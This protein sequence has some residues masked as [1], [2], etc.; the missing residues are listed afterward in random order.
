MQITHATSESATEERMRAWDVCIACARHAAGIAGAGEVAAMATRVGDWDAAIALIDEQGL[1]AL[2]AH[3]ER[4]ETAFHVTERVRVAA[5]QEARRTLAL[6]RQ[7]TEVTD[8]LGAAGV[9]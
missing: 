2:L 9:Q 4:D 3:A 7:L 5:S 8:V 1:L 6:V